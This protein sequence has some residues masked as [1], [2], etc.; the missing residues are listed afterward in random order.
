MKFNL[1]IL[2]LLGL[3]TFSNASCAGS[4]E[5]NTNANT[6]EIEKTTVPT[7]NVTA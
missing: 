1:Y 5:T 7:E 6:E 4:D 2:L 3:V